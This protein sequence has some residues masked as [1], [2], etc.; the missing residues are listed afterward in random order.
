[1]KAAV[2]RVPDGVLDRELR[3]KPADREIGHGAGFQDRIEPRRE[4]G[5]VALVDEEGLA[6]ERLEALIGFGA[7]R[8]EPHGAEFRDFA[9]KAAMF[10]QVRVVRGKS[11]VNMRDDE[12]ELGA[13]VQAPFGSPP[14]T[15]RGRR[16]PVDR[17]GDLPVRVT[18]VVLI[19]KR[20]QRA[21]QARLRS[22]G[23]RAG[24]GEIADRE[25]DP[26]RLIPLGMFASDFGTKRRDD[27]VGVLSAVAA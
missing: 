15:G 26:F 12:A 1:M 4:E 7:P 3:G 13:R 22:R 8:A 16:R 20:N 5:A 9:E 24:R 10:R 19:V 11:D 18:D 21:S 23:R 2:G 27:R 25:V 6:G 14:E 17:K